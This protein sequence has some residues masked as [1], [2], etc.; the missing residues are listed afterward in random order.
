MVELE[1]DD[2][3]QGLI[4][5]WLAVPRQNVEDHLIAGGPRIKGFTH[6][7]LDSLQTVTQ[8][9]SEHPNKAPISLIAAAQFA[10]QSGKCS[11]TNLLR[12]A[13]QSG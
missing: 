13:R 4:R 2:N 5:R 12:I 6:R 7:Y 9:C 8:D 3:A 1:I 10:P 11:A